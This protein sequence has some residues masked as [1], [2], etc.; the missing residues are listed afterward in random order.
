MAGSQPVGD[1]PQTPFAVA[2]GTAALTE[3]ERQLAEAKMQLDALRRE[4]DETKRTAVVG[5]HAGLD[6]H[7]E[8][9]RAPH[10]PVG[11]MQGVMD[12]SL[13]ARGVVRADL[14]AS[15]GDDPRQVVLAD[16]SR[17]V[18]R[19]EA[20]AFV[21]GR[22]KINE[23]KALVPELG[24]SKTS[25]ILL[26]IRGLH[27]VE[28]HAADSGQA[29]ACL[30]ERWR[31]ALGSHAPNTLAQLGAFLSDHFGLCVEPFRQ[32]LR[33]PTM[34][35]GETIAEFL[36]RWSCVYALVGGAVPLAALLRGLAAALIVRARRNTELH[37]ALDEPT[38]HVDSLKA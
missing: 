22:L 13:L 19:L 9:D 32:F 34:K 23:F 5:A 15:P 35:P 7:L 33:Q 26:V 38:S 3:A 8:S 11:L 12:D 6:Q 4:L 28:T 20:L 1:T 30:V 24:Q 37:A 29:L 10:V 36:E 14:P 21:G 31:A 16:P 25:N 17:V 18:F 27:A 2:P